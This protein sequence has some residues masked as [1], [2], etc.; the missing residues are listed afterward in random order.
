[1]S[2]VLDHP[3]IVQLKACCQALYDK[4]AEAITVLYMGEKSSLADFFVI[5][6]GTSDPH[7]RALIG[8]VATT[9]KDMHVPVVG[10]DRSSDSGWMVID[11]YDF[12][13]HV[14]TEEMRD[15][16]NLEGLWKDAERIEIE[17]V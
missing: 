8:G 17:L 3:S 9:L 15:H 10:T 12:L 2:A 6:T 13:V 14:F 7:L 16:Y 11:A 4:K 1:M 5:A